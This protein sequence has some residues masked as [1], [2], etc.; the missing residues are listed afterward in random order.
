MAMVHLQVIMQQDKSV[1]T[2]YISMPQII[3]LNIWMAYRASY[4][5]HN[6]LLEMN[7]DTNKSHVAIKKILKYNPNMV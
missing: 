2:Q 4:A 3:Q 6:L 7:M 5:S 1:W